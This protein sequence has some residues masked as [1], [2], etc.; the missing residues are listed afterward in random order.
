MKKEPKEA[1]NTKNV[2][3]GRGRVIVLNLIRILLVVA[4]VGSFYN[5]RRLVLVISVLAFVLTYLPNIFR[6]LLD[7]ELPAQFEVIV[8]LFIYG[9]LFFGKVQGFYN[10]FWWWGGLFGFASS[11]AL[12]FVGMT[13]MYSLY[14][15]DK[16]HG[17]PFM[18]V[19]FAFCFAVAIGAVWELLE[20]S[21]DKFLGFSLQSTSD[22]MMDMI[23]NMAG[24]FVVSSIG[25]YY[26]KNG[27][28]IFISEIVKRFVEKNPKIFGNSEINEGEGII[29]LINEGES[30]AMEFKSTMRTNLHTKQVDKRMEHAVLKTVA[31]YLNSSG[32]TL[33]IGVKDDGEIVGMDKDDFENSDKANLH[34]NALV[35]DHLG[36]EYLPFVKTKI[37]EVNGRKVLKIECNKSNKEIYLKHGGEESFY[38][39][40]GPSSIKLNGRA[41]VDYVNF[42]FRS[43][44]L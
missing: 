34:F 21:L 35:K 44:E 14:K 32:G 22:T 15:G 26:I 8:I 16:I 25:Y 37:I 36:G 39:R 17:S 19:F 38:I 3:E 29:N 41:L 20:F 18:I 42:K 4:F 30:E 24:A 1:E 43:R 7:V 5:G 31:A 33:L 9:A 2:T 28:V 10:Q 27:K 12:G 23:A 40:S 6:K 11:V 13:V